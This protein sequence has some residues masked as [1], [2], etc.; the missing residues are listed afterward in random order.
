MNLFI[1][2]LCF[3]ECAEALFDKH[4]SKIILEAVQMLCTAKRIIDNV[5]PE[6]EEDEFLYKLAH[7]NHPVTIWIRESQENYIWALNLVDAMHTEW[8]FRYGH[9]EDKKHKSFEMAEYLCYCVPDADAFPSKG[10]TP[11]AQAMP[12]EYKCDDAV[13]AY[14]QYYQSPEKR[15]I[16]TWKNR[17]VPEWYSVC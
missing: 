16:A 5:Q 3:R 10:L 1:L 11:F 6:S 17:D 14:R 7:K 9:K 2:S 15:R 12:Q 13:Q 8:K 4:V